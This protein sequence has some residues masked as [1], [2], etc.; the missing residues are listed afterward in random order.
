MELNSGIVL[1]SQI[2]SLYRD[3]KLKSFASSQTVH[4]IFP[5]TH[6]HLNILHIIT[7]TQEKVNKHYGKLETHPNKILQ[8]LLQSTDNGRRRIWPPDLLGNSDEIVVRW[9]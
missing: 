7:V 2:R 8:T 4:G 9:I 6:S 3:I 1:V 5:I